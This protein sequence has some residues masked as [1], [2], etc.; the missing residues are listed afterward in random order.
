[1][2]HD[3]KD[4][5]EFTEH[6]KYVLDVT[7]VA[8]RSFRS[9]ESKGWE[10]EH[11][12]R[13]L[14][15]AKVGIVYAVEFWSDMLQESSTSIFSTREKAEARWDEEFHDTI[16]PYLFPDKKMP[17]DEQVVEMYDAGCGTERKKN[18]MVLEVYEWDTSKRHVDY[19]VPGDGRQWLSI[20][21][22]RVQ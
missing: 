1:M 12:Y 6:E 9:R 7:Q 18:P 4:K 22:H 17:T 20:T 21:E 19:Y 3:W 13:A 10:E 8:L 2:L 14:T 11:A 16:V 15:A 5:R